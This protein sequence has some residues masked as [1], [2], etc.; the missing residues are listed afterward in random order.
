[1]KNLIALFV[2]F[3]TLFIACQPVRDISSFS[4]SE[5]IRINQIGYYPGSIKQF[6]VVDTEAALFEVVDQNG[7]VV[8]EG[9]LEDNGKW[10]TSGEEVLMGDFSDLKKEGK[11]TILVDKKLVSYPFEIK[12][13]VYGEALKAAIKS[14]YFQ[15]ASMP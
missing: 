10:E 7:K 9:K 14:Y 1:M 8:F 5:A 2:V 3:F 4:A 11:F 13:G 15:R 6:A 12:K